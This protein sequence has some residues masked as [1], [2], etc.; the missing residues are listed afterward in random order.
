MKLNLKLI[1]V[2]ICALTVLTVTVLIGSGF[3]RAETMHEG[4]VLI[5]SEQ[6]C[7]YEV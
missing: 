5:L 4:A 7:D 3:K 6:L 2:L 1:I